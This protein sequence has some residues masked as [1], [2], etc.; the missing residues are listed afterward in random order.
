M[1]HSAIIPAAPPRNA[2]RKLARRPMESISSMQATGPA[3][4]TT[5]M[6]TP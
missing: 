2:I 5:L 4:P 3:S 1:P 6:M